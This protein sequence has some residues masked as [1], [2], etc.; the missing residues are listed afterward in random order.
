MRRSFLNVL[1]LPSLVV[2]ATAVP[3]HRTEAA[4]PIPSSGTAVVDGAYGE[5]DLG[6]DFFADMRRAGK[7]DKP[8]ESK[9]YLRY[10]CTTMTLF[11]LVLAEPG[12]PCLTDSSK[13]WIAVDSQNNKL[14]N[15][16]SGNDGIP[17]DYACVGLGFD[18]FANHARGYEASLPLAAGHYEIITHVNVFDAGLTQTSGTLG[19]PGSGPDLLMECAPVAVEPSTWSGIKSLYR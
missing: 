18:G 8:V 4:P 5:W 14:V 16:L 19:F 15:D 6:A 13:A 9:L 12:V 1:L 7:P 11:A 10:D 3:A 2:L 17:P